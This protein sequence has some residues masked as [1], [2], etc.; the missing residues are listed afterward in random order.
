MVLVLDS[1]ENPTFLKRAWCLYEIYLCDKTQVKF[2]IA[3]TPTVYSKVAASLAET[4]N[5]L[6][7]AI[8]R[9]HSANSTCSLPSDKHRILNHFRSSIGFLEMD[10]LVFFVFMRWMIPQ[11]ANQI[12]TETDALKRVHLK[13]SLASL[14]VSLS[15]YE[16]ALPLQSQA[17]VVYNAILG[18]SM[19]TY[20]AMRQL[21]LTFIEFGKPHEAKPL[22]LAAADGMFEF[23]EDEDALSILVDL[24]KCFEMMGK[25]DQALSLMESVYSRSKI[26]LGWKAELTLCC[27]KKL[28]LLHQ[29]LGNIAETRKL[30]EE[31]LQ[32][33]MD[34]LDADDVEILETLGCLAKFYA[35]HTFLHERAVETLQE[36]LHRQTS[37]FGDTHESV[38]ATL[39][40]LT[41]VYLDLKRFKDAGTLCFNTLKLLN[42]RYGNDHHHS[43]RWLHELALCQYRSGNA[44][45]AENLLFES[46]AR[47][48]SAGHC[49]E[50][51]QAYTYLIEIK[52][53]KR[54]IKEA[55][56]LLRDCVTNSTIALGPNHEFTKMATAKLQAYI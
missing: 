4:P 43:I 10:K 48:N 50:S 13:L 1:L 29:R 42:Q 11:L 8:R 51:L 35:S 21:A 39:G 45:E 52:M 44:Q 56:R 28:G 32:L 31:C 53:R 26:L 27:M 34:V 2:N 25:A 9:S 17:L 12:S 3:M 16:Q 5:I 20:N 55:A 46:L 47:R 15:D 37:I 41:S 24:S 19:R 40:L 18:H 30:L 54:D 7:T 33:E 6:L 36:L 49:H 22:F 14:H 38:L 23:G